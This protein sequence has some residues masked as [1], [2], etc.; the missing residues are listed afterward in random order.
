MG[1]GDRFMLETMLA[2]LILVVTCHGGKYTG[3]IRSRSPITPCR[4]RRQLPRAD[5]SCACART[6]IYS[7]SIAWITPA[8]GAQAF[9]QTAS[10]ITS[11]DWAA[12][13]KRMIWAFD[14][15]SR[16]LL[17][18]EETSEAVQRGCREL[19]Q[20][21]EMGTDPA[22]NLQNSWKSAARRV[23]L[24]RNVLQREAR[25]CAKR[26]VVACRVR[27]AEKTNS[28]KCLEVSGLFT[29]ASGT[30]SRRGLWIQRTK[31]TC[32]AEKAGKLYCH[33]GKV[34]EHIN[35]TSKKYDSV[36]FANI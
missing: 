17:R 2:M 36:S 18:V 3:S 16:K 6:S 9:F 15:P 7:T 25:I 32:V 30:M 26:N 22:K 11:L 13:W 29:T 31:P 28:T 24:H 8:S 23:W 1:H 12:P 5:P 33:P 21:A 19:L 35:T 27:T 14:G 4:V 10:N 34:R 20:F